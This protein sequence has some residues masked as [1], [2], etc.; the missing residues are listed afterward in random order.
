MLSKTEGFRVIFSVIIIVNLGFLGNAFFEYSGVEENSEISLISDVNA[1]APLTAVTGHG[2]TQTSG[3]FVADADGEVIYSNQTYDRYFDVDPVEDEKYTV[4]YVA[5][6]HVYGAP[7]A[8]TASCTLNIIERKNLSTDETDR[9][10]SRY[11]P[12]IHNSRWHDA[13]RIDNDRYLIAGIGRSRV[14]IVNTSTELIEWQWEAQ[15]T[16]PISSGDSYP[17]GEPHVQSDWTHI[18]DVE[19]LPDGRIMVSVRNHN[20]IIFIDPGNGVDSE[21]T[22]GSESIPDIINRQHNPDFIPVTDGGPSVLVG[23]SH[24]DRAVE[25]QREDSTWNRTWVFQGPSGSW[26]R[27]ADRLPNGNTLI[28]GVDRNRVIEVNPDGKVIWSVN[29][30][31]PYEAERIGSGDESVNGPSAL[32]ASIRSGSIAGQESVDEQTGGI[33]NFVREL[34]I[35]IRNMLPSKAV[36]IIL[37]IL[38]PWIRFTELTIIAIILITSFAWGI[39][40]YKWSNLTL[41]VTNPIHLEKK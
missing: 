38:P 28:A 29:V 34:W 24:N 3:L 17:R 11:T 1:K 27:D 36:S 30:D 23:D 5:A 9:I 2:D 4:E 20:Q 13:D 16:F 18:N 21:W 8:P 33:M 19:L 7:C 25:Y 14:F 6:Q 37:Y 32:S 35:G 10:Y 15:S 41:R 39:L 31:T 22:L 40:E 12:D 26:I